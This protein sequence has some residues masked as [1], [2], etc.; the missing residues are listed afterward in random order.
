LE[1][2][3]IED[4]R[5]GMIY[6]IWVW[7]FPTVA[8][9]WKNAINLESFELPAIFLTENSKLPEVAVGCVAILESLKKDRGWTRTIYHPEGRRT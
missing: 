6:W 3:S 1:H 4:F 2:W 8:G 9:F 7:I 5:L